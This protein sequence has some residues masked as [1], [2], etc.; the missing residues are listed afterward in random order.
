ML[1]VRRLPVS[2]RTGVWNGRTGAIHCNTHFT[3]NY[4]PGAAHAIHSTQR[5]LHNMRAHDPGAGSGR[6]LPHSASPSSHCGNSDCD[7]SIHP[8]Q[9]PPLPRAPL[10][11]IR[12][13]RT[14]M[15][16]PRPLALRRIRRPA[17]LRHAMSACLMRSRVKMP[18]VDG[19]V[20][21]AARKI[22]DTELAWK[23]SVNL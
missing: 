22:C 19:S 10:S 1:H 2:L 21:I 11:A 20:S 6:K 3:Y 15:A 5:S 14:N 4:M 23:T 13:H 17:V 16:Q 8:F 9:E 18:I 7:H 12:S